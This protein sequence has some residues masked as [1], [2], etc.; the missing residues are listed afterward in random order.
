MC[1]IINYTLK[2]R[3]SLTVSVRILNKPGSVKNSLFFLVRTMAEGVDS[4]LHP[5]GRSNCT[6]PR[7]ISMTRALYMPP[8][9]YRNFH[10]QMQSLLRH[11]T[12]A[13]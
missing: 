4:P 9:V 10:Y 7:A 3:P 11:Y 8:C 5:R 12:E 6:P 13:L 2:L 1:L